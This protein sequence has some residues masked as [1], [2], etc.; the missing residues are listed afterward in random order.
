MDDVDAGRCKSLMINFFGIIACLRRKSNKF[1]GCLGDRKCIIYLKT[2]NMEIITFINNQKSPSLYKKRWLYSA[3]KVYE[4]QKISTML[5]TFSVNFAK[6]NLYMMTILMITHRNLQEPT[7]WL[8]EFT[9]KPLN[10]FG[11]IPT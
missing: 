10:P 5:V 4:I 7:L 9:L 6:F 8:A 1:D 11:C 2:N 3:C